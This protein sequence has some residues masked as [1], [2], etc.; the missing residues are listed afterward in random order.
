M[1]QFLTNLLH[2]QIKEMHRSQN[3]RCPF[4]VPS[5]RLCFIHTFWPLFMLTELESQSYVHNK[6][7]AFDNLRN[8]YPL[9]YFWPLFILLVCKTDL[10]IWI[11]QCA[12]LISANLLLSRC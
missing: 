8:W 4:L 7:S 2:K 10:G 9:I 5:R 12:E 6:V 11:Q 1:L 3:L